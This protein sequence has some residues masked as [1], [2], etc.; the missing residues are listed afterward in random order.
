MKKYSFISSLICG[1]SFFAACN[2]GALPS[3]SKNSTAQPATDFY[4]SSVSPTGELSSRVNFPSIQ[5]QFSKPVVALEKLGEASDKNDAVSISPQLKGTFRWYGTSLLSF[6]TSEALIPQKEYTIKINENLTAMDGTKLSGQTSYSFR[7]E[8]VRMLYAQPGY[9]YA[10]EHKIHVNS[11]DAPVEYSTDIAIFFSNKIQSESICQSIKLTDQKGSELEYTASNLDEKSILLKLKKILPL[12]SNIYITLKKGAKVAPDSALTQAEQKLSFHTLRPFEFQYCYGGTSLYM[13]FNHSLK[14]GQEKEVLNALRIKVNGKKSAE[15]IS[16]DQLHIEGNSIRI[17]EIPVSFEDSYSVTLEGGKVYDAYGQP[18]SKTATEKIHVGKAMSFIHFERDSQFV[19]ESGFTP[20]RSFE[21]QNLSEKASYTIT[22]VSGVSEKFTKPEPK[23]VDVKQDPKNKNKKVIQTIDLSPYLEKCGKEYRGALLITYRSELSS[24][25]Q[26]STSLIQVTDLGLTVHSAWNRTDVLVSK[27]SNGVPV[28]GASVSIIQAPSLRDALE[29]NR[30]VLATCNSQDNGLAVLKFDSPSLTS[31]NRNE[32]FIEAKTADDRIIASLDSWLNTYRYGDIDL[33]EGKL[34]RSRDNALLKPKDFQAS[35]MVTQIFSDRYLYKPG[36]KASFKIIDRDLTLGQYSTYQGPYQIN[37]VDS[38][39]WQND[40]AIYGSFSGTT[41]ENGTADFTWTAP[42]DLAPGTYYVEYIRTGD[43]KERTFR[44][45]FQ[46]QVFER[47]KFQASLTF[48][49]TT[50][51]AGDTI[52]AELKASYLGGGSLALAQVESNWMRYETYFSGNSEEFPDWTFGPSN[53]FMPRKYSEYLDDIEEYTEWYREDK[54]TLSDE[55]KAQ[56]S[57]VTGEGQKE[58]KPYTYTLQAQVTDA[59]NQMIASRS[60]IMVHP[61]EFYLGLSPFKDLNTYPKQGEKQIIRWAAVSPEGSIADSSLVSEVKEIQCEL[62]HRSYE[63]V[64]STDEFGFEITDWEE[65]IETEQKGTITVRGRTSGAFYVCPRSSGTYILRIS[66]K[67]SKGRSVITEKYFFV[68][69]SD[70]NYGNWGDGPQLELSCDKD[71][72]SSGDT[73][74]ILINT[75]LPNGTYLLTVEREGILSEEVIT[76]NSHSYVY[77]LEIKK[78]WIPQVYV[79]LSSFSKREGNPPSERG[80]A[81]EGLPK[82]LMASTSL[83]IDPS[84]YAFDV[85]IKTD[86]KFYRPGEQVTIDLSA[87]KN[88]KALSGAE[89]TLMVVDRG[90]LDLTVYRVQD[91]LSVFYNPGLFSRNTHHISSRDSLESP[92]TYGPYTTSADA[93]EYS[94][95]RYKNKG[96][97]FSKSAGIEEDMILYEE[98]EMEMKAMSDVRYEAAPEATSTAAEDSANGSAGKQFQI[99]KNFAATAVFVPCTITDAKGKAKAT[100][101][102]PDSLT[103][104]VI[105]VVGVKENEYALKTD[106]LSATNPISVRDAETKILRIGDMGEA[107]VTITNN[108]EVP[109]TVSVSLST[110][111]GLEKTDWK[112][113]PGQLNRTAGKAEVRGEQTK[114]LT[115]APGK[116]LA[117]MYTLEAEQAGWITLEFKVMS[118]ELNEIIY[119]E[120]EI[121]KPYVLETVTTVGQID[122]DQKSAEE[123]I[124][125][126]SASEDGKVD[127][128]LQLDST[129]LGTLRSAVDYVFHYPYGCLEQRSSAIL[130]LIVFGDYIN[131]FGLESEVEDSKTVVQAELDSWAQF[132]K[133]DGGFPYWKD[134]EY[135]SFAVSLRIAEIIS[136]AEERGFVIP[137]GINKNRLASYIKKELNLLKKENCSYQRAYADYV[138][139]LLGEKLSSSELNYIVTNSR[140]AS[141]LAFAG[142]ACLNT[143]NAELAKQASLKIKNLM[144]LTT[145]GAS[146]QDTHSCFS[147]YFFNGESE[148]FALALMLFTKLDASDIYNQHLMFQL[149][150]LQKASQGYW[151]TTS[152]TSRVLMAIDTFIQKNGLMDTDFSAEALLGGKKISGAEFKGLSSKPE[153]LEM[154]SKEILELGIPFGKQ[155]SLKLNKNGKGNL[156]YTASMTY[157]VPAQEQKARDQGISVYSEIIDVKTGR[158]VKEDQLE[159]GKIYKQ[160]VYICSPQTRTFLAVR[161]P[162]PAGCEILNSAFA[163]TATVHEEAEQESEFETGDFK[164]RYSMSHQDIYAAEVRCFWNYFPQGTQ[165]FEFL[166]RAERAGEYDCPAVSAECMY[167]PEIFGRSQGRRFTIK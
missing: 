43:K 22:P 117:L 112:P 18:L 160:K 52:S 128:F 16:E 70:W 152:E 162:V 72:Y 47:V 113:Q 75:S 69:G 153:S 44:S 130:P 83:L 15:K 132:Q 77:N 124:I 84:D 85:K 86:K 116:T 8:D 46:V 60:S 12:D 31:K 134:S 142:L 81:D 41:S 24:Y 65:K 99:R 17:T 119:K 10:K 56:L 36:E 58:G 80:K 11:N 145:R 42:E 138:L 66:T 126:P 37:I 155:T 74:H 38:Q 26:D 137:K 144:S 103:E 6:D 93:Y 96:I 100:F 40:K 79:S 150:E 51:F 55:G 98:A 1:I 19:L 97:L 73:A 121:E 14:K 13:S 131:V 163:T 91:P 127:F 68:T 92:V 102:L 5:I 59:S 166:F 63:K 71:I 35:Q 20:K 4:V 143:D 114:K 146:F 111:S 123:F 90:V 133:N 61:A 95:R 3:S 151:K 27:L 53:S 147:W 48:P 82:T 101:T 104:Y 107:G 149:L 2:A 115:V 25:N 32:F 122:G 148:N 28:K 161:A 23:T 105:T 120:L 21:F 67:D 167:E 78:E 108:S 7:T 164:R 156:Y 136:L 129:K 140:S 50:Y 30:N 89:L 49:P 109:Q 165:N 45:E 106:S 118:E 33:A 57:A 141:E 154:N 110:I 64:I 76:I 9:T 62:I 54:T 139:T 159:Y 39:F 87:T 88:S 29:G 34:Y 135:S 157:A 158:L 94:E 125:F